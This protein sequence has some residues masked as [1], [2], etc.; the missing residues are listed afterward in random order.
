MHNLSSADL[1]ARTGA[2]G[3]QL[4][5]FCAEFEVSAVPTKEQK[6][7]LAQ[8]FGYQK[9]KDKTNMRADVGIYMRSLAN[10]L[11][12]V[13]NAGSL[14]LSTVEDASV[15]P[16]LS[17]MRGPQRPVAHAHRSSVLVLLGHGLSAAQATGLQHATID[18][19]RFTLG[20]PCAGACWPWKLKLLPMDTRTDQGAAAHRTRCAKNGAVCAFGCGFIHPDLLIDELLRVDAGNSSNSKEQHRFVIVIDACYS[21]WLS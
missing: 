14:H 8:R 20:D 12:N 19:L 2:L 10:A 18:D 9:P 7:R 4:A 16:V 11:G 13:R 6:D 17:L 1:R 3:E 5:G 15:E 21:G